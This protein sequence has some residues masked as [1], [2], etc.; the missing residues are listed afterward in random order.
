MTD[1]T[2]EEQI[3]ITPA[4]E[5]KRPRTQGYPVRF[6]SG[7]V[8]RLRP[9]GP[10]FFVKAGKIPDVMSSFVAES[11]EKGRLELKAV[12]T[13]EDL[14][15]YHKLLDLIA[16]ASFI[17][18]SIERGEI[19]VEDIDD[20]DKTALLTWFLT[21]ARKLRSFRPEQI[22]D[23]VT[24]LPVPA[25]AS[26]TEPDPEVAD[27]VPGTTEG[28]AGHLDADHVRSGGQSARHLGR[29]QTERSGQK[30]KT[31]TPAGGSAPATGSGENAG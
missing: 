23:L 17:E 6:P 29:K 25:D 10:T 2:Q 16:E 27:L 31:Q 24:V 3:S 12:K 22:V 20:E 14:K 28:D 18:P 11:L 9:I 19:T 7:M 4:A 30:G 1:Q 26:F 8:A 15:D 5:W 21:P 13:V